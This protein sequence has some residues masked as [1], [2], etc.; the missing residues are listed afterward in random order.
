MNRVNGSVELLRKIKELFRRD[1]PKLL[2]E[3]RAAVLDDDAVHLKRSAHTLKGSLSYFGAAAAFEAAHRLET[4]GRSG[5]LTEAHKALGE[6]EE[7]LDRLD[8]ALDGLVTEPVP[9]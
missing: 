2:A 5:D 9:S 7:A 4:L 1:S 8:P 3:L 6:L